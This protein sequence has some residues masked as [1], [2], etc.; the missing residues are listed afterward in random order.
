MAKLLKLSKGEKKNV[1]L[2]SEDVLSGDCERADVA[3]LI[4]LVIT[5]FK[6]LKLKSNTFSM[7]NVDGGQPDWGRILKSL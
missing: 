1:V 5:N 3:E 7:I 6:E 2:A 4:A